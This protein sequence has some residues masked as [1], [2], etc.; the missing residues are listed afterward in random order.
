[1]LTP[2]SPA[3]RWKGDE[4]NIWN[5]GIYLKKSKHVALIFGEEIL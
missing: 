3:A 5:L 2:P 4:E 1:M